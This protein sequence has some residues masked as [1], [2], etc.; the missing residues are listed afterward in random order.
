MKAY[1]RVAFEDHAV[2]LGTCAMCS[3]A[4]P[5]RTYADGGCGERSRLCDGCLVLIGS[6]LPMR[7]AIAA[8]RSSIQGITRA[9][10]AADLRSR[11][12]PAPD[13][14]AHA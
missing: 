11:I 6:G 13:V 8:V 9:A 12:K 2:V 1:Q 10:V 14:R 3:Q 4:E 5:T 7:T